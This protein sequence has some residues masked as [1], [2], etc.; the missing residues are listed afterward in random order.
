MGWAGETMDSIKSIQIR[1]LVSQVVSLGMIVTSALIIWKALMCFTG[2]ESPVVVVLSG[3]MEPGFKRGDI[4]FL[5]MSKDPIRAGEIVVFNVDGR[6]IPIVH[7]VIKVHERNDT[8]EVDVLTKGDNNFGDDRL[9]YAH[10]QLWL[11]RH[12]IMGRAV[13][14]LPYV[15]WVTIIMTEKPIVKLSLPQGRREGFVV[16]IIMLYGKAGMV[17][18]A[19]DTFYNMHLFRCSCTVKSF[20]AALKVL[21]QTRDLNAVHLFLNEVSKKFSIERDIFSLNIAIKGFC[22]MGFLDSAYLVMIEMEKVGIRP[23]V[24]TYTTLIS[25]FYK[26]NKFEIG[27][28]LWNLMILRRCYPNLTTFNVR[29]QYLINKTLPWQANKLT[30]VM[31]RVGIEPDDMTFNLIIKGFFQAGFADMAKNI[32]FSLHR[33][34]YKPNCKI[35]QTMVHYLCK[36]GDFDLACTLSKYSMS[37]NW[38]PSVDTVCK[39]LEGLSKKPKD[40]EAKTIMELIR[41]RVP[42]FSVKEIGTFENILSRTGKV[43]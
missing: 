32:Y 16:R 28:G 30:S 34:G 22:D 7:R 17:N 25:A 11:H 18:Q 6:E 20:N 39:L 15:G 24:I 37:K 2:S 29:I 26:E 1:Q 12:H 41:K 5:H 33:K 36:T 14:F 42:P 19:V 3:S 38:F 23:D 21:T 9:L 40:V 43:D 10:G 4:L 31:Q 27:N 8:G 13:G 35:Y